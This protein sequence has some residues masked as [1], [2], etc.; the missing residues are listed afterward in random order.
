MLHNDHMNT[1][2]ALLRAIGGNYTLPSKAFIGI[3]E[4]LRCKDVRTYIA[5]GNAVFRS[6]VKRPETLAEK[7]KAGIDAERGF[8]PEVL[9]LTP[10]QLAAAIAG[11]PYRKAEA[12]PTSLHLTFLSTEPANPDLEKLASLLQDGEA[13]Q[14]RK[15]IFYFY[16]PAGVGRSKAFARIEKSLGVWGTGRNWRTVCNVMKLAE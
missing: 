3:L 8:A 2:I 15:K 9:I 12:E 16:A 11:N 14:L 4:G 13:F 10:A 7:I 5:T 6:A 1:Y